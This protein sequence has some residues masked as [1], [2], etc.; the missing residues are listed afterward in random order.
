MHHLDWWMQQE[1]K[2][3]DRIKANDVSL[4]NRELQ[5]M[6]H[7]IENEINKEKY[8]RE[9]RQAER[10]LVQTS[11]WNIGYMNNLE[12]P[13]VVLTQGLFIAYILK[14]ELMEAKG[15][16]ERELDGI[17]R[18]FGNVDWAM[19]LEYGRLKGKSVVRR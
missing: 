15:Y 18:R 12:N 8:E 9:T 1:E 2:K 6:L 11:I 3:K 10:H 7:R 5:L 13:D 17:M 14:N 16:Y 19:Y 4:L